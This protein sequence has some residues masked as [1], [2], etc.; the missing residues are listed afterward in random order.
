MVRDSFILYTS[1]LDQIESMSMEQRGILFTALFQY[2][3]DMELPKMDGVTQM[4]FGFIRAQVDRHWEKYDEVCQKR[5]EAG[6]KGGRP[7]KEEPVVH[8]EEE[9]D[10][11]YTEVI[12]YLNQKTGKSYKST[13]SES[14]K[15]IRERFREGAKLED[16]KKVVDNKT[17]EWQGTKMDGYLRPT[18]LFGPKFES[19]L[20]QNP[21]IGKK[22]DFNNFQ[23]RNYN[24]DD[25]ERQLLGSEV[26]K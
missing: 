18:T 25:L 8:Q 16:F 4:A 6:R 2:A 14:R 9:Q 5:S 20:Q 17:S 19:Y 13:S 10:I 24:M 15:H 21:G 23:E 22:T 26:R 11:P 7:K 1:Y 12:D 3:R